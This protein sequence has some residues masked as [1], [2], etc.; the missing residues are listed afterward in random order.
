MV[1]GYAGLDDTA[2]ALTWLEKAMNEKDVL[3]P[4]NLFDPLLDPLRGSARYKKV[5]ERMGAVR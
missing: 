4:E 3:L 1:L 5:A 2:A